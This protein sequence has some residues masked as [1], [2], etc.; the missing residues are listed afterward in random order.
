MMVGVASDLFAVVYI[1]RERK[2]YVLKASGTAP[3]GAT[4]ARFNELGYH[5]DPKKWGPSS[6]MPPG[7]IL[8]VTV[9]G[10]V[11]GWQA[12]LKRFGTLTF[13]DVLEPAA[14]YAEEGFPVSERIAHDW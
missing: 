14:R 2:I 3:S 12:V 13:K 5:A 10:A 11:W 6:G 9:P 8:T 1:A 7:G 4:L